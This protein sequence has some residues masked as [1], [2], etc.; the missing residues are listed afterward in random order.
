MA[1]RIYFFSKKEA[2]SDLS[3]F[4]AFGFEEAGVHWP[5]VEH[6]FQAQKFHDPACRERIRLAGGPRHA[7]TVGQSRSIPI[8][9]WQNRL[10]HLLMKVRDEL[11]GT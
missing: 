9:K 1:K 7:K 2:F 4:A 3:N 11:Q 10:G 8:G 6:Y 5:T